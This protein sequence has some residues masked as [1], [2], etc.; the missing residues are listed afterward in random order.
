MIA[1]V[2][3]NLS[4]QTVMKRYLFL[5]C[6]GAAALLVTALA[7]DPS[8]A[9]TVPSH[10]A[11]LA[12]QVYEGSADA[13]V[14]A[15]KVASPEKQAI[16]DRAMDAFKRAQVSRWQGA[17]VDV[18]KP[19]QDVARLM[20][21]DPAD[22]I[23]H[24]IISQLM[25]VTGDPLIEMIK[26]HM[27]EDVTRDALL[28]VAS[29]VS[30]LKSGGG[31]A[32]SHQVELENGDQ[33]AIDWSPETAQLV[34]SALRESD[35]EDGFE[36][37]VPGTTEM[38]RDPETGE[39]RLSAKPDENSQP[40]AITAREIADRISSIIGKWEN[41][42][43][44]MIVRG[45][46]EEDGKVRRSPAAINR[47]IERVQ[48][49]LDELRNAKEFVWEHPESGEI[50]RQERFRRLDDPWVY[51]GER[52]LVAD[53]GAQKATLEGEL[54]ALRDEITGADRP[55]SEQLDPV[56][57][58]QVKARPSAR[59]LAIDWTDKRDGCRD[60]VSD[61]YFDGRRLVARGTHAQICSMN[62]EL[63][64][65][66]KNELISSWAPPFWLLF[67]ASY[68]AAGGL[69]LDGGTWGMYVSY[70]PNSLSVNR[71]FDPHESEAAR[72]DGG[73]GGEMVALGAAETMWP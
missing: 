71:I 69:V 2:A 46:R 50:I 1:A 60:T 14:A 4:G 31:L 56:A 22:D 27:G 16:F 36:F 13:L 54:Q 64:G 11:G 59:K 39:P 45:A 66:I 26:S 72:F 47:D 37:S 73:G 34:L 62:D 9:Q 44:Q 6:I 10:L 12:G 42:T 63:P 8:Y 67:T 43:F 7:P 29:A 49:E 5:P 51:Q 53:G 21:L 48:A 70:D 19:F 57:F 3:S 33:I 15:R 41:D 55:M 17:A 61:A 38:T 68:G 18:A 40:R 23:A 32:T 20:N 65:A 58:E 25:T 30:E 52:E 28:E 24:E 35:G